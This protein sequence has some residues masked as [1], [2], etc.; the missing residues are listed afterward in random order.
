MHDRPLNER[1]VEQGTTRPKEVADNHTACEV[2]AVLAHLKLV[3]WDNVGVVREPSKLVHARSELE[4]VRD[5]A[6]RLWAD[7]HGGAGWEAAA[8]RDASRA[9]LAVAELA[10]ANPVLGGAHCVVLDAVDDEDH[11]RTRHSRARPS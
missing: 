4:A 11:G 6:D 5:E 3:M 8:L 9:G 7:G 2:A 1:L 10:A